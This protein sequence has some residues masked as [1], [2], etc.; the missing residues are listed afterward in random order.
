MS[1]KPKHS[2]K[3]VNFAADQSTEKSQTIDTNTLKN[4]LD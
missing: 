1:F 2:I 4:P 3:N